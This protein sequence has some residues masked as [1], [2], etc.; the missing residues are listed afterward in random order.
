M[1]STPAAS[2]AK[3]PQPAADPAAEVASLQDRV[4]SLTEDL[5]AARE[6]ASS[7][8]AAAASAAEQHVRR[9]QSL[10]RLR[11]SLHGCTLNVGHMQCS[12]SCCGRSMQA[13]PWHLQ[14]FQN[15]AATRHDTT[16]LSA[17]HVC[18]CPA[19]A[20]GLADSEEATA[21]LREQLASLKDALRSMAAEKEAADVAATQVS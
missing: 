20:R 11:Q 6:A 12:P 21:A 1:S 4:K 5:A 14:P 19:Q 10:P 3:E 8:E 15:S 16:P 2:P 7:A 17:F 9:C 13:Y 18:L